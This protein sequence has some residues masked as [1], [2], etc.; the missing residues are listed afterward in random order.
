MLI[1][2]LFGLSVAIAIGYVGF[3]AWDSGGFPDTMTTVVYNL[4]KGGRRWLWTAWMWSMTLL[5]APAIFKAMP[6]R[7]HA[8]AHC[9]V[10]CQLVV[11]LLPLMNREINCP[12]STL[13]MID[14]AFS[15]L[16]VILI[17]PCLMLGWFPIIMAFQ[18]TGNDKA[19]SVAESQCWLMLVMAVSIKLTMT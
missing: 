14:C 12:H 2:L 8:V 15:Q 3:L 1:G 7:Y 6:E 4:Q 10:T 11:A 17:C 5:M 13:A 19:L 18:K 9:F 16:C